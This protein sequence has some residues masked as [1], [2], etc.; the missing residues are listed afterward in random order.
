MNLYE[1]TSELNQAIQLYSEAETDEQLEVCEKAL[2]EVDANYKGK[3]IAVAKFALNIESDN[4]Q[5]DAEIDRLKA[6]KAIREH[7]AERLRKYLKAS[8]EATETKEVDGITVK[9]KIKSNPPR[10][11]VLNEAL[12]PSQYKKIKTTETIDKAAIKE[13]W[14]K[15][16]GVDGTEVVR[17]TRLEIK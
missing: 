11:E 3:C 6:I 16:V 12:V 4:A 7:K 1:L 17:G 14:E 13:S 10:V 9:L 2:L 8:M 15:G 5:I